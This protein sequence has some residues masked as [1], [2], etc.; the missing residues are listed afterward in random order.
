MD[1]YSYYYI[2]MLY[3]IVVQVYLLTGNFKLKLCIY[4]IVRLLIFIIR[5]ISI[6]RF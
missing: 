6:D 2:T 3:R 1:I 5:I 4:N